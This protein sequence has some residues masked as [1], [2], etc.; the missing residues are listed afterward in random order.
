MLDQHPEAYAAQP[1]RGLLEASAG[2]D[3]ATHPVDRYGRCLATLTDLERA[4]VH[5]PGPAQ[6]LAVL[7]ASHDVIVA[8]LAAWSALQ[9][10]GVRLP[11]EVGA[12]IIRDT[13]L[14]AEQVD[15]VEWS[16]LLP[17]GTG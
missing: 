11:R 12:W 16:W 13:Y 15:D 9:E 6:D 7:R 1:D 5:T 4:A 3:S 10:Q 2:E 17:G 8:R 14:L